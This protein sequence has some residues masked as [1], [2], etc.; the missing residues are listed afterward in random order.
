[1]KIRALITRPLT[2]GQ[3]LA[4]Q[5]T[6]A[7]GFALCC[8]FVEI[9]PGRDSQKINQQMD[10]LKP[11]DYIIA[12]SENAVKYANHYLTAAARQW[13]QDVHCIAVGPNTAKCW[14]QLGIKH[15]LIPSTYDS[16]GVL[17]LLE[18]TPIS[19]KNIL[20]LRGN[21]GRE[22]IAETLS[23]RTAK[24]VYSEVYQ[25]TAPTYDGEKLINKWLHLAINSVII[26]SGEILGNVLKSIPSSSLPW[27]KNLYF[28]V[29]SKRIADIAKAQ[30]INHVIIA[31]GASNS[32]LFAAIKQLDMQIGIS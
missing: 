10:S 20:I 32:S 16:E 5:I 31:D 6:A 4:D 28:I 2:K 17:Q 1:M 27:F 19:D 15:I 24:V 25:R 22:T 14:Q 13:P 8:P 12:V 18:N 21:G 26:T 9:T 11:H 29:P 3:Q 23:S 7:Q 30:G